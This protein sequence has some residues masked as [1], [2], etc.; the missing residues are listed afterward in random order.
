MASSWKC[1]DAS[2]IHSSSFSVRSF[3]WYLLAIGRSPFIRVSS[4]AKFIMVSFISTSFTMLAS[5]HFRSYSRR[6]WRRPDR[7]IIQ[8]IQIVI[9]LFAIPEKVVCQDFHEIRIA[10][11]FYNGT[12]RV[13]R[14]RQSQPHHFLS[15]WSKWHHFWLPLTVGIHRPFPPS[16][17]TWP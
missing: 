12:V 15:L 1:R 17:S 16:W 14:A 2:A 7:G 3:L 13:L 6:S 8:T 9:C 4:L 11:V 5:I 10:C